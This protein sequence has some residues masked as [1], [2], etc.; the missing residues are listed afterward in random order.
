MDKIS[1]SWV[2]SIAKKGFS[3]LVGARKPKEKIGKFMCPIEQL[4]HFHFYDFFSHKK[5]PLS[6]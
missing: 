2:P 1:Y 3:F 5:L 6:P 4:F